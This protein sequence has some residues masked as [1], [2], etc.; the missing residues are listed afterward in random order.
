MNATSVCLTALV[1]Q[2]IYIDKLQ[3]LFT[4]SFEQ[5]IIFL[6]AL[7]HTLNSIECVT[8]HYLVV[9]RSVFILLLLLMFSGRADVAHR[10]IH[11]QHWIVVVFDLFFFFYLSFNCLKKRKDQQPSIIVDA[12][13]RKQNHLMVHVNNTDSPT[14]QKY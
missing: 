8:N 6:F 14:K 11:F 13:R 2:P 10:K 9:R 1:Y 5:I 7:F 12:E 3:I 4:N